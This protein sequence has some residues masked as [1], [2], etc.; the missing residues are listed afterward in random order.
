[1]ADASPMLLLRPIE[2]DLR[3]LADAARR[4]RHGASDVKEAAERG[5]LKI[6]QLQEAYSR[7]LRLQRAGEA[8]AAAAGAA[9]A[10]AGLSPDALRQN[11]EDVLRPFLLACNHTD[12]GEKLTLLAFSGIQA[13]ARARRTRFARRGRFRP[14]HPPAPSLPVPVPVPVAERARGDARRPSPRLSSPPAADDDARALRAQR[15]L[16]AD[17]VRAD[18]GPHIMR[19]LSIQVESADAAVQVRAAERAAADAPLGG[20]GDDDDVP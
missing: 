19:V 18:Y 7:A 11:S 10:S 12:A 8:A 5:I 2:N 17:A 15:L 16:S 20:G 3:T 9:A 13:R 4:S 1:M 14:P 6:R